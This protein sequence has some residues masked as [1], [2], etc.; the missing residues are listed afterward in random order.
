[1]QTFKMSFSTIEFAGRNGLSRSLKAR[2]SETHY[3]YTFLVISTVSGLMA[4]MNLSL[5][6]TSALQIFMF[7]ASAYLAYVLSRTAK[8]NI[9]LHGE[10]LF[11]EIEGKEG[12]ALSYADI[13]N[14]RI[15]QRQGI[16]GLSLV[17]N[18]KKVYH[19]PIHLER[20]DYILDSLHFHRSDLTK[21][22]E[23]YSFRAKALALDHVLAHHKTFSTK[24]P[25]EAL[26]FY[27]LYPVLLRNAYR[28]LQKDPT[29]LIRDLAYEKKVEA[30]CRKL[31]FGVGALALGYVLWRWHL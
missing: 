26:L 2:L 23:F 20:L 6:I 19:F 28:R 3:I 24:Q 5:S 15:Q 17:M 16:Y 31:H 12:V 14:I 21:S 30:L 22:A 4:L 7:A 9:N 10:N 8:L 1:M 25:A 13:A 18:S 11:Y 29:I 27:V